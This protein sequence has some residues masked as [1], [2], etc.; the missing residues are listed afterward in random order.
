[1]DEEDRPHVTLN[2]A[3]QDDKR[4]D[5]HRDYLSNLSAAI[6]YMRTLFLHEISGKTL[7]FRKDV[8]LI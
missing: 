4:M 7:H 2:D 6:R 8:D 1:M 3:L 5:F